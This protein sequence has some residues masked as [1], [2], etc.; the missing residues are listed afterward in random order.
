MMMMVMTMYEVGKG[1][2]HDTL[3]REAGRELRIQHFQV[4]EQRG[5][6]G[7]QEQR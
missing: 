1:P 7:C 6:G 5:I 2:K 4:G 3:V